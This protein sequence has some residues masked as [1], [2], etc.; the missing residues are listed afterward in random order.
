MT[1]TNDTRAVAD[2]VIGDRGR[3]VV[4][5]A[6]AEIR[7]TAT[8][9]DRV[10]VR[11]NDGRRLPD[12]VIVETS[13]DGLTIREEEQTGLTF[14]LGRKVVELE[15]AA[16]AMAEV[17]IDTASG[18]VHATGMTGEQRYRTVSGEVMLVAV[19]GPI[20]VNTVSG[21]ATVDLAGGSELTVRSVSGD[22]AVRGGWLD[23][24]R[25]GTTSG[26]VRIDSPIHGRTDNTIETLSGDVSVV[27][28]SGMR[29]EARTVSGGLTSDLPHRSEGRMGR[30]TLVVGDGSIA[31]GFRSVSGDL[32]IHDGSG[33]PGPGRPIAPRPPAPPSAPRLPDLPVPPAMPAVTWSGPAADAGDHGGA[34][35][36][37]DAP[38][39][40][41]LE[42]E[43]MAILR[44][45]EQ[46]N[47]DVAS[48]MARLAE[49][50]DRGAGEPA[51][52]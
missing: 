48:A 24:L 2:H 50:D 15:I 46:G 41:S 14:S 34:T 8:D 45:L 4:R 17:S 10:V 33:R 40:E 35:D 51:D 52:G 30:R 26:D 38:A 32:R 3:L 12:R 43:R 7:L 21:E 27:A 20:Q 23:S 25:V 31:L 5:L 19:A 1:A 28:S 47:L 37:D 18:L 13:D 9:G 11:T 16:P 39:D 49:L 42:A 36:P 22:I 6:T 29:V 44:D